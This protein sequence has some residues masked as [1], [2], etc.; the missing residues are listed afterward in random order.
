MFPL[1]VSCQRIL[2]RNYKKSHLITHSQCHC[3][4]AHTKSSNHTLR[5]HRSTSN[6]SSTTKFPWLTSTFQS[7]S[8]NCVVPPNVFKITPRHGPRTEYTRHV[9]AI[10]PVHWRAGWSYRKK[11]S[12]DRYPVHWRKDCCLATSY[13]IRAIVTCAYRGVFIEPLPSN[14]LNKSIIL[15]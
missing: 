2:Y 8:L 6:S 4:A 12:C 15:C 7:N 1:S 9:F 14:A 3:T 11:T 13:N 10:P 5:L